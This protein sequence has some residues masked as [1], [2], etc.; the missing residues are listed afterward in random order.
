MCLTAVTVFQIKHMCQLNL[1]FKRSTYT[2]TLGWSQFMVKGSGLFNKLIKR[3][4]GPGATM[5]T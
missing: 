1:K 3:T 2:F 5:L 4:R